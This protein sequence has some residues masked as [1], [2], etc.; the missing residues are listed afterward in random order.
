MSRKIVLFASL[1]FLTS[2][3][4]EPTLQTAEKWY[5]PDFV[6]VQFAGNVGFFSV[7]FGYSVLRH[8]LYTELLYGYVPASI[9]KAKDIHTITQKN[10]FHFFDVSFH[11][12]TVSPLI[13]FTYIFETGNS[14]FVTLPDKY[15]ENYYRTNAFH[16]TFYT[17]A[18]ISMKLR[19]Q[20]IKRVDLYCEAGTVDT[21]LGYALMSKEVR[22]HQIT[23]LALGIN[24][25]L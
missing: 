4:N 1:F 16:F 24:L 12:I 20:M 18:R 2:F 23:S 21:Y 25:F 22:L 14:S 19:G 10:T 3:A 17:G 13:G 7:G 15:P 9:S 11:G 5:L 6:K 8:R